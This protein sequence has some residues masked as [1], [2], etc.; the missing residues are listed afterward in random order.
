MFILKE[1]VVEVVKRDM[2]VTRVDE[3]GAV[4]GE[5]SVFL[6]TPHTA[7]VRSVGNSMLYR[8]DDPH[9][10]LRAHTDIS[11]HVAHILAQR[12]NSVTNNLVDIKEQ[13]KDREDHLGMIDEILDT[14]V[15]Q[16]GEE[17]IP[18]SDRDPV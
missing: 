1:G 12:L 6:D 17:P 7:T 10:F 4:F 8:V 3:P 18:G 9:D 2:Q 16:Q 11:Y 5:M 15:H 13:F 14:L